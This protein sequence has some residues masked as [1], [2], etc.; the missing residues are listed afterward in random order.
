S[1]GRTPRR[2]ADCRRDP[3]GGPGAAARPRG[4]LRDPLLPVRRGPHRNALAV[5]A[6]HGRR[7]AAGRRSLA[8]ARPRATARR[9]TGTRRAGK[10]AMADPRR[11][12][13]DRGLRARGLPPMSARLSLLVIGGGPAGLSAA[14]FYREAGGRG[15]VAIVADEHRMPYQ[16]PPL[17]K[18]LLR[19][20][21]TEEDLPIERESWLA[22][23]EVSLISG[24][25][26]A[27][28]AD[29]HSVALS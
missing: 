15:L 4:R 16:R 19:G 27:L 12:R 17:T 6:L 10:R 13:R 3:G 7:R 22:A 1:P 20:D 8:P 11:A 2:G 9:R 23:H 21:T 18:E 25:A 14:R 26:V 29:A 5:A 28:D 24:R